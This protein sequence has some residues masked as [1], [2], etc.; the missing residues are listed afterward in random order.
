[1]KRKIIRR[2]NRGTA[3]EPGQRVAYNFSGNIAMGT[4]KRI[5]PSGV[6]HI[7]RE[8]PVNHNGAVSQ[9]KDSRGVMVV[10]E[11]GYEQG[12]KDGVADEQA[13]FAINFRP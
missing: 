12:Y 3:L 4:I 9:V 1:M 11:E 2:D 7:D 13:K 10:H 6:I 5:T 8:W